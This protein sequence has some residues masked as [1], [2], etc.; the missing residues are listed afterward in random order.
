MSG[1][2]WLEKKKQAYFT[3]WK[4]N[5]QAGGI[6][7]SNAAMARCFFLLLKA[8]FAPWFA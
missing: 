1:I 6:F 8:D 3:E 2:A 5:R 7:Y 4:K